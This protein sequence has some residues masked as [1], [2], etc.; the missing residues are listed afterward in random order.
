MAVDLA[1]VIPPLV[2]ADV[3]FILMVE[4]RRFCMDLRASRSM[5]TL[6]TRVR[7]TTLSGSLSH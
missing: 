4:W 7:T 1:Q 2:R 3:D 6:F 5:S